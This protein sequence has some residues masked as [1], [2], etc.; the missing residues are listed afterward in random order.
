MIYSKKIVQKN[1]IIIFDDFYTEMPD[2]ELKLYGAQEILKN[3]EYYLMPTRDHVKGGG[4]VQ[5]AVVQ[6]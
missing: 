6:C 2:E 5:M 3:E 4:R 1:G